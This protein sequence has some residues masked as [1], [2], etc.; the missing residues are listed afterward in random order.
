MSEQTKDNTKKLY[1]KVF[2]DRECIDYSYFV[3]KPENIN[4]IIESW[5]ENKVYEELPPVFEPIFMTEEEY[6]NLPDF[7]GY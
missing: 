3:D 5:E 6:N 2:Q 1:F 7:Q 4:T